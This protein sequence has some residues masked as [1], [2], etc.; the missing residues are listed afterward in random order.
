MQI[1]D[2]YPEIR[3]RYSDTNHTYLVVLIPQRI[4]RKYKQFSDNIAELIEMKIAAKVTTQAVEEN[5]N[6]SFI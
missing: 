1:R 5:K 6:F 4:I 3:S 2:I